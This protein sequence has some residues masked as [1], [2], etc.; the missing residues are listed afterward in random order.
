MATQALTL[1]L[2]PSKEE[3]S[4]HPLSFHLYTSA[5]H[6]EEDSFRN[7]CLY[8]GPAWCCTRAPVRKS[9]RLHFKVDP[10]LACLPKVLHKTNPHTQFS[11][12]LSAAQIYTLQTTLLTLDTL[13][14]A[15]KTRQ[16]FPSSTT[17]QQ[18]RKKTAPWGI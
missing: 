3:T 7:H 18:K 14:V 16:P 4:H 6:R 5:M 12:Q 17:T 11:A 8:A 1:R 9:H 2:R 13:P 15:T 10:T